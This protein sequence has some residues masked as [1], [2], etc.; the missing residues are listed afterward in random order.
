MET[1]VIPKDIPTASF[2]FAPTV[3][4]ETPKKNLHSQDTWVILTFA[5]Y[6]Y[7]LFRLTKYQTFAHTLRAYGKH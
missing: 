7:T 5:F 3:L 2:Y 1:D 4:I 6:F